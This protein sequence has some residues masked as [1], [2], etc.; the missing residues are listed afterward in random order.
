MAGLP[1]PLQATH[2]DHPDHPDTTAVAPGDD[3]S[4]LQRSIL[5]GR[6]VH[7]VPAHLPTNHRARP[8]VPSSRRSGPLRLWS[9]TTQAGPR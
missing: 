2:P 7:Y 3:T 5:D 4:T 6:T 1:L 8:D 9:V